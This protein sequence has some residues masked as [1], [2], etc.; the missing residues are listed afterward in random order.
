MCGWVCALNAP[1]WAWACG[2]GV[3]RPG[4]GTCRWARGGELAQRVYG[5]AKGL[6]GLRRA[7]QARLALRLAACVAKGLRDRV[8][9]TRAGGVRWDPRE[10]PTYTAGPRAW[11]RAETTVLLGS[12]AWPTGGGFPVPARTK[13]G[14]MLPHEGSSCS[15]T[16]VR[17]APVRRFTVPPYASTKTKKRDAPVTWRAPKNRSG[18]KDSTARRASASRTPQ[19]MSSSVSSL[20]DLS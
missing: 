6:R 16:E 20:G 3:R 13:R 19:L 18:Q 7:G 14:L 10:G 9:P 5:I 12:S 8:G 11:R 4:A 2:G 17:R 1:G 15:R